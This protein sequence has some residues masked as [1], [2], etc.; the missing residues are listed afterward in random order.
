MGRPKVP[1]TD[2]RRCSRCGRWQPLDRFSVARDSRKRTCRTCEASRLRARRS[3]LKAEGYVS[4][5]SVMH[6]DLYGELAAYA[7][8]AQVSVQAA[9]E[10]AIR[11]LVARER[12]REA[13]AWRRVY[14]AADF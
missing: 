11:L 13:A 5:T 12:R 7:A 10:E 9:L 14:P 3:R 2:P 4:Y 6:P 1:L 8:R